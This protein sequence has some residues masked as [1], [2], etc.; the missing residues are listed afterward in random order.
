MSFATN[1]RGL[2]N[3][4]QVLD[5]KPTASTEDILRAYKKVS[6]RCHPSRTKHS[7]ARERFERARQAF[8]VLSDT[9][10]RERYN[11]DGYEAP[12]SEES[13]EDLYSRTHGGRERHGRAKPM[14]TVVELPVALDALYTGKKARVSITRTRLCG[15][16]NGRGTLREG[17]QGRCA[18]CE[19]RGELVVVRQVS[20][21]HTQE[22]CTPCPTCAARGWV[23]LPQDCCKTC[24]GVRTVKQKKL[25][26][27]RVEKGMREGDHFTQQS[28]GD[29]SPDCSLP[30]DVI[31]VLTELKH[32]TF[33]RHGAHLLMTYELTLA[34][35]L[36]GF[37]MLVQH[38]DGRQLVVQPTRGTVISPDQLWQVDGEGLPEHP[39]TPDVRGHLVIR[40]TVVFPEQLTPDVSVR[41]AKLLNKPPYSMLLEEGFEEKTLAMS[42]PAL[43]LESQPERKTRDGDLPPGGRTAVCSHQ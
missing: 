18:D 6:A 40:F 15:D 1:T 24:T 31:V 23:V 30:G 28:E 34:E 38:L 43:F 32:D 35:A 7:G 11:R 27:F 37:H 25:F 13:A 29:E 26:T 33:K 41:L 42:D 10:H 22:S 12:P 5:V 8:C 19:G 21:L 3:L 2:G 4:Y 16:C 36:T 14:D 17:L 9:A 20:A 39:S